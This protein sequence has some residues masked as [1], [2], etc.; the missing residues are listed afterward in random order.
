MTLTLLLLA[1]LA[2]GGWGRT[3]IDLTHTFD[4]NAPKYP[5]SSFGIPDNFTLYGLKILSEK[6]YPDGM[7]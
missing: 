3:L 5:Q 6:W 7:W 2:E 1:L 4:E